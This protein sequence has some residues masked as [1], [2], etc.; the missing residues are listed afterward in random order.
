MHNSIACAPG[1][2]SED[3]I[4]RR[5]R[6]MATASPLSRHLPRQRGDGRLRGLRTAESR[7]HAAE[8]QG[9]LTTDDLLHAGTLGELREG[10][11]VEEIVELHAEVGPEF[12]RETAVAVLAVL[13]A[14]AAG[15]IHFFINGGDDVGDG[16]VLGSPSQSITTARSAR[17]RDE[18]VAA[19]VGE[20]LFEIRE[21]YTLTRG[22][23]S[24][25]YRTIFFMDCQIHHSG[26]CI[27]AFCGYLLVC[28][29]FFCFC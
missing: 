12:V 8:V 23:I 13:L 2:P 6:R 25:C 21:G 18:A 24:E 20:D 17:A 4:V 27:A 10:D 28:S 1:R 19:Q 11:A 7:Q 22:Y 14:A 5:C 29:F 15:D 3:G 16:D 26:N 9:V